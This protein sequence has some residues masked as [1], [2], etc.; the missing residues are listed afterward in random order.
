MMAFKVMLDSH[1]P[2]THTENVSKTPVSFR[3]QYISHKLKK[4]NISGK[5]N[6][7]ENV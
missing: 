3:C 4:K 6:L 7:E 5:T 1:L 2:L